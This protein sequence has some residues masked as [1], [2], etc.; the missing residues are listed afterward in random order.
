MHGTDRDSFYEIAEQIQRAAEPEERMRWCRAGLEALPAFVAETLERDGRLPPTILCRDLTPRLYMEQGDWVRAE[1]TIRFCMDCGAYGPGEGEAALGELEACRDAAWMALV[2]LTGHPGA[3]ARDL[4]KGLEQTASSQSLDT[5]LR[6]SGLLLREGDRLYPARGGGTLP[7]IAGVSLPSE[8]GAEPLAPREA[9]PGPLPAQPAHGGL[10]LS[11]ARARLGAL[12]LAAVLILTG[13]LG[14]VAVHQRMEAAATAAYTRGTEDARAEA[15]VRLRQVEQDRDEAQA[16]NADL[17]AQL[18]TLRDQSAEKDTRIEDL[19]ASVDDLNGQLS[20]A[21]AEA[22]AARTASAV[23]GLT[24]TGGGGADTAVTRSAGGDRDSWSDG[25]GG[26]T[27][28]VT[29]SG[30]KY[31]NPGCRYLSNSSHAMTLS[32]AQAAG[33]TPCSVCH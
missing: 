30:T 31:H 7:V 4:K 33:Y 2:Y 11:R 19:Q 16:E 12:L 20:Q 22:E 32:Q 3:T 17:S 21:K 14:V 29:S 15:A 18:E 13:A 1:E 5:V 25:S 6:T 26:A 9:E 23:T 10:T 28:Y 8:T 24:L 27:V